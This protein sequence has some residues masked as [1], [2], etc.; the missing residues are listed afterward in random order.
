MDGP[1]RTVV[2]GLRGPVVAEDIGLE[3]VEGARARHCRIFVDGPTALSAFLPLR[4]L[5][6]GTPTGLPTDLFAWRG[7]LDWWVFGDGQ[8]GQA[9]IEVSGLRSD[10][11]TAPDALEGMLRADLDVTD[12]TRPVDVTG[13]IGHDAETESTRSDALESAA[14]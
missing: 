5:V 9:A 7:D 6:S 4:W 2:G 1:A 3:V 14:P 12:R 11:W 10:A 13:P 8:L